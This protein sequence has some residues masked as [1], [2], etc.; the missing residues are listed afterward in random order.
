MGD[1]ETLGEFRYVKIRSLEVGLL[2]CGLRHTECAC[3]F[4]PIAALAASGYSLAA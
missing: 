1:A 4:P 3:Y 2:L